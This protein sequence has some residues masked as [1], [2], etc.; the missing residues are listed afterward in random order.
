MPGHRCRA[1]TPVLGLDVSTFQHANGP[2]NWRLLARHGMRFVA[3]KVY[4]G[5]YYTN[6]YY[7]TDARAAAAAR[8][9]VMPY[10]FANPRSS[11]G[12]AQARFGVAAGRYWRGRAKL[13]LVVDLKTTRTPARTTPG[14]ATG[15]APGG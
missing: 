13:P 4:E 3:I 8:L 11:G 12:A 6:P 7:A 14:T 9:Y 5:T 10:V 2:I 1:T 15:S